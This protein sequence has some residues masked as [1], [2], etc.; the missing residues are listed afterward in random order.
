VPTIDA[1]G[2]VI[3]LVS[4]MP[5]YDR[6]NFENFQLVV[7]YANTGKAHEAMTK[8]LELRQPS[9]YRLLY[10]ALVAA[11]ANE[12]E[13]VA[14]RYSLA[15]SALSRLG[16]VDRRAVVR[17]HLSDINVYGQRGLLNA[18]DALTAQAGA[19]LAAASQPVQAAL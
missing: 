10:S 9:P 8:F 17:L 5:I 18:P 14:E 13:K 16:H 15:V 4:A 12:P 2:S 6:G 19:C 7:A 1:F 11:L 3:A